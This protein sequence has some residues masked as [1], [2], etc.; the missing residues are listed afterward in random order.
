MGGA[1]PG[2]AA[3]GF[4][5]KIPARGDFVAI[6]LPRSFTDPWHDWIEGML[7]SSRARL[8]AA[9]LPAWLEGPVWR[10]ALTPGICGP[11]AVVGLSLPSVD[12]VGRYFPLTLAAVTA[13]ADLSRLVDCGG[14]FL[15]AA[16][17]A[18][19]DAL[20]KDLPPEALAARID[21]AATAGPAAP[22]IDPR[23]YPAALALWW[24]EGGP[25]VAPGAFAGRTLPDEARF[26]AML[27]ASAAPPP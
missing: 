3:A 22:G 26:A 20:A 6:G 15:S 23:R 7:A 5:G 10:F 17:R 8:D 18:G 24:T 13:D 27:D 19:R 11:A 21:A 2:F 1:V 4:H 16:E 12:R 14:G 9:W 25:R